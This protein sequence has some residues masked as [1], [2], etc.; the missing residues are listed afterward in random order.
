MTKTSIKLN[1]PQLTANISLEGVSRNKDFDRVVFFMIRVSS[2]LQ[3]EAFF[4]L[5]SVSML[6]QNWLCQHLG[7]TKKD[8]GCDYSKTSFYSLTAGL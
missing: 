1:D 3:G 8:C 2:S 7:R 6:P 5:S 4:S